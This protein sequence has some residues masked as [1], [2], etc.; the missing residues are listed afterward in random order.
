M[1]AFKGFNENLKCR[2]FQYEVGKEYSMKDDVKLCNS[3]FHA[4]ENPM[5]VWGY[6]PLD[7]KNKFHGVE[8]NGKIDK[9][10]SDDSKVCASIIKI[11]A[12]ISINDM[13]S[14]AVKFI[15]EKSKVAV[16]GSTFNF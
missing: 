8:L 4:C 2:D 1:K 16:N 5:D 12:E 14:G 15:F 11:G 3:G 10:D 7:G 6:Y 9:K 13:I